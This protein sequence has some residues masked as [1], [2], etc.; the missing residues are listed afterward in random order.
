MSTNAD[1][2]SQGICCTFLSEM[3]FVLPNVAPEDYTGVS[4]RVLTFSAGQSSLTTTVDL[5]DDDRAEDTESFSLSL[6]SSSQ[7]VEVGETEATVTVRDGDS[8]Y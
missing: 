7:G 1:S 5:T 6:S 8:E 3:L 2:S 4:D